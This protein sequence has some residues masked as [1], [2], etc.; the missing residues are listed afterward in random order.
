M[1]RRLSLDIDLDCLVFQYVDIVF[2]ECMEVSDLDVLVHDRGGELRC[3][4][5][6]DLNIGVWLAA[7]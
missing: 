1:Q 2:S 4:D 5:L 7:I 3:M 6:W